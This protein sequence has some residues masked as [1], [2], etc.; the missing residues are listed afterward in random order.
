MEQSLETFKL[1]G[2]LQ[3]LDKA[4]ITGAFLY[5]EVKDRED[6]QRKNSVLE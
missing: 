3:F 2:N 4:I 5:Q 6:E 1:T